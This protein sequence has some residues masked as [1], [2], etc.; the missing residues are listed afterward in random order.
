MASDRA[1]RLVT[2]LMYTSGCISTYPSFL[3]YSLNFA[4]AVFVPRLFVGLSITMIRMRSTP[5]RDL[6][7]EG[8]ITIGKSSNFAD[9]LLDG[10]LERNS[11]G[12]HRIGETHDTPAERNPREGDFSYLASLHRREIQTAIDMLTCHQIDDGPKRLYQIVR[13]IKRVQLA[14]MVNPDGGMKPVITSARATNA[15]TIA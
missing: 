11:R 7:L 9:P 5:S 8:G 2:A 4:Y 15:R 6:T 3:R 12:F 10:V 14:A 1:R 13:Q